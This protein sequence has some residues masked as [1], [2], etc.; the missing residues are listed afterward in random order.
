MSTHKFDDIRPYNNEEVPLAIQRIV[1][2]KGVGALLTPFLPEDEV[3]MIL[4]ALP[5]VKTIDEFQFAILKKLADGILMKAGAELYCKNIDVLDKSKSYLFISNHRDIV[6]DPSFLNYV[7]HVNGFSTVEIAI[8]NNL[9]I[10]PWVEDLVRVNKSFI[11]RRDVQGRELFVASQKMSEYIRHVIV[12]KNSNVW[13]AQREGRA[14]DSN[15]ATQTALLKMLHMGAGHKTPAESYR[16]LH[17]LP[18]T[19]SY[20][21]DPCDVLKARELYFQSVGIEYTKTASDDLLSMK[22]G[23]LGL[24][25]KVCYTFAPEVRKNILSDDT[26]LQ[27]ASDVLAAEIDKTIYSGYELFPS[28]FYAFDKF[29]DVRRFDN[30]Y[31]AEKIDEFEQII[32]WKIS[33]LLPEFAGNPDFRMQVYRQYSNVLKNALSVNPALIRK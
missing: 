23:I 20:E 33:K 9:L 10:N 13:I 4:K 18:V 11:V 3:E 26:D 28:H 7:L 15:D 22:W 21:Y 14:K 29:H 2:S 27:T 6:L 31:T 32:D 16:E 1:A 8:G 17:I 12:E 19:I 5:N 30:F 25:G 24:R